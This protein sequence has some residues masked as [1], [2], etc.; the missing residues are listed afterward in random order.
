[1]ERFQRDL[2][3]G[4]ATRWKALAV[5]GAE[6]AGDDALAGRL[7]DWDGT[8]ATDDATATVF[9]L[10]WRYLTPALFE[11]EL[12]D[13]WTGALDLQEA[14]L[15]DTLAALIDDRRTPEVEDAAAI[16]ARAIARA[17]EA[18]AGRTWGEAHTLTVRHP[19]AQVAA[20]DRWLG[21]TRGPFPW[22]GDGATLDAA[23][24]RF[25]AAAAH[26]ET[27]TGPSMRFVMDW[28]DPD[29][30]TLNL[31]LGQ[32]GHP[33]SPHFADF[34]ALNRAG[35]RWVVPFTRAAV[36]ARRASVLRLVPG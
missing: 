31:A 21:L 20:L 4:L 24:A 5:A 6:R 1:M 11:D 15:T 14:V 23:F 2:V 18:A 29:G 35:R 22:P 34:L 13:G 7:R 19:L 36:D 28:A 12:G 25:D 26:F 9:E 33:A 17:V 27:A 10:W 30:F 8:T 3:S 32:S 16:S